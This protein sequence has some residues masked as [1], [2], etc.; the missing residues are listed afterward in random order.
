MQ[1]EAENISWEKH[2]FITFCCLLV[3]LF[4][5]YFHVSLKQITLFI[6]VYYFIVKYEK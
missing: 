5:L 3:S 1:N 2:N 4:H 6:H